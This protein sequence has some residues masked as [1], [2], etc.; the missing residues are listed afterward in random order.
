MELNKQHGFVVHRAWNKA[1]AT[2]RY[3]FF[4]DGHDYNTDFNNEAD[5][6]EALNEAWGDEDWKPF[7]ELHQVQILETR[8]K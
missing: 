2:P 7:T 8:I 6:I 3:D 5:L 4:W 1:R